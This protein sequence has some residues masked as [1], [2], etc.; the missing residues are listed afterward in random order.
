MRTE[1]HRAAEI[2]LVSVAA[3]LSMTVVRDGNFPMWLDIL[4][5]L[6]PFLVDCPAA[7]RA[8][9]DRAIELAK[10]TP[11]RDQESALLRLRSE[12]RAYFQAAAG[13]RL[14]IVEGAGSRV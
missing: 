8:L 10:A 6:A 5:R 9:R 13:Q 4:R 14:K 2:C 3:V 7:M 1:Q 12:V 11:G